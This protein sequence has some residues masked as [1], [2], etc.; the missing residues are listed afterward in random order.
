M[1]DANVI[2]VIQVLMEMVKCQCLSPLIASLPSYAAQ[3]HRESLHK[4][5]CMKQN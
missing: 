5:M 2:S 1:S 4:N 3:Y